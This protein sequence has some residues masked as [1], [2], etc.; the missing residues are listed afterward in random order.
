MPHRSIAVCLAITSFVAATHVDAAAIEHNPVG[1]VVADK[2]PRFEARVTPADS[3]A[4]ARVLFRGEGGAGWYSVVM[5]RGGDSFSAF[6]PKPKKSLPRFSYYVEVT[7]TAL[8]TSR[9]AEHTAS[10]AAGAATCAPDVMVAPSAATA[11]VLLEAPSGAA[12][13]PAGFSGTSV[14]AAAGVAAGAAGV[15]AATGGGVGAT[16]VI[17]AGAGVVAVGAGALVAKSVAGSEGDDGGVGGIIEV[18]GVVYGRQV[19]NP[20][21]PAGP[22]L[23]QPPIAGAVVSTSLDSV[24]TTTDGN[25]RFHLVTQTRPTARCQQFTLTI[26]AAGW[27]TWTAT[28]T[29]GNA[30]PGSDGE[31][32]FT[33]IPQTPSTPFNSCF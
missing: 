6:L 16:T 8:G 31:V 9:T 27:P 32:A 28:D 21:D 24:T 26:T 22:G 25:G 20:A 5:T 4:R 33:L 14:V 10:V 11:S 23:R 19:I 13:V 17:V 3:V 15:T 12:A 7:D 18:R 2:F 1:C 30:G 29:F